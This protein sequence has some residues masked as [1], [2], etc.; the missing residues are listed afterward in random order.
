MNYEYEHALNFDFRK[1]TREKV[2]QRKALTSV[3]SSLVVKGDLADNFCL[4]IK[5]GNNFNFNPIKMC[6]RGFS[7]QNLVL[8]TD[9]LA[10]SV[11]GKMYYSLSLH[12]DIHLVSQCFETNYAP[13]SKVYS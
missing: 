5:D 8:P 10:D 7:S 1:C 13:H 4:Q 11:Q 3:L 12:S 9:G 2:F 6:N